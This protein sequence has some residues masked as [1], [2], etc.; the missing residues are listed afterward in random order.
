MSTL[1][2][3]DLAGQLHVIAAPAPVSRVT[4]IG[5]DSKSGSALSSERVVVRHD[6]RASHE[7]VAGQLA[8]AVIG[9]SGDRRP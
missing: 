6:S 8:R 4:C 1:A 5:A 3:R 7:R 9:I 2:R